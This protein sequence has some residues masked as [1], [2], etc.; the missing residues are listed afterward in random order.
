MSK[1]KYFQISPIVCL[2]Y[3]SLKFRENMQYLASC[4]L[5]MNDALLYSR[6]LSVRVQVPD[7]G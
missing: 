6:K 3:I 2:Q 7:Y 1:F 5:N 4:I